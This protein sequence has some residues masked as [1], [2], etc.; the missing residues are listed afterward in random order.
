MSYIL[1]A[2][3]KA[4][5]DRNPDAR[6]SLAIEQKERRRYRSLAYFVITALLVNAVVMIWLFLPAPGD[7]VSEP[8]QDV[9]TNTRS[10]N[11]PPPEPTHQIQPER[12][13]EQNA[14]PLPVMEVAPV[15]TQSS[16]L[17]TTLAALP[18]SVRRRFPQLDFTTHIFADDPALRAVVV[19][20][21]RLMEGDRLGELTIHEITE[22]GAVFVFERYL[23]AVSVLEGWE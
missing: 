19:N 15:T 5:A 7:S 2:L 17:S 23:V 12:P 18:T 20:G 9:R 22:E 3:K 8:L 16:R 11:P 6:A 13:A 4:E 1:D 21:S 14:A 10:E